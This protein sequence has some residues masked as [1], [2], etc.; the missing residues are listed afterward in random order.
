MRRPLLAVALLLSG[1]IAGAQTASTAG[2]ALTEDSTAVY[3]SVT[4]TGA[5]ELSL[6]FTHSAGRIVSVKPQLRGVGLL[7]GSGGLLP[8]TVT[9]R[10]GTDAAV[11]C[12][13]TASTLLNVVTRLAEATYNCTGVLERAD[14]PRPLVITVS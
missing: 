14:R 13:V 4:V 7:P 2:N 9:A 8:K 5:T 10:F 1:V 12:I 3:R 11:T 6:G